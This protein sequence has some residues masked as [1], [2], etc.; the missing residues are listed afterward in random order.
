M[1]PL[2]VMPLSGIDFFNSDEEHIRVNK[3]S[4]VKRRDW[5]VPPLHVEIDGSL[6]R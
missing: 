4:N 1:A 6:R 2:K 5:K 3:P